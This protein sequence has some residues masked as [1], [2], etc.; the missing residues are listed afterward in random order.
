MVEYKARVGYVPEEAHLYTFL[1]GR[2]Q[3]E[4]DWP[5]ATAASGPPNAE[6]RD[7]AGSVRPDGR[8]PISRSAGTPKACGRRS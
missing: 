1:S 3:L 8:L 7:A 6:D 5:A 4:L 2:E